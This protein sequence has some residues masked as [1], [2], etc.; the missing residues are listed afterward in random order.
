MMAKKKGPQ[1]QISK[2]K[3]NEKYFNCGKKIYYA[4]DCLGRTNPK[5]KPKVEKTE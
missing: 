3:Q 4:R 2:S 5:K 1:Q